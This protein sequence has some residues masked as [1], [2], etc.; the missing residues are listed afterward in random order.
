MN[1][2]GSLVGNLS[3]LQ[4]W[5]VGQMICFRRFWLLHRFYHLVIIL[6]MKH[7][8]SMCNISMEWE[9]LSPTWWH[10]KPTKLHNLINHNT[11]LNDPW[12]RTLDH[13]SFQKCWKLS[14]SKS[15][16]NYLIYQLISKY[17]FK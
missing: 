13:N 2:I 7:D 8:V 15:F 4:A 3:R 17:N 1:I 12:L 14:K 9:K 5:P 6:S 16:N 11:N 10:K